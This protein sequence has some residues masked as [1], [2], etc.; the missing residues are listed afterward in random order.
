MLVLLELHPGLYMANAYVT[1][2]HHGYF[3][4]LSE[5]FVPVQVINPASRVPVMST[6]LIG[7]IPESGIVKEWKTLLEQYYREEAF[8]VKVEELRD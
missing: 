2:K 4:Q 6:A 7:S 8:R 3:F 1:N 5:F